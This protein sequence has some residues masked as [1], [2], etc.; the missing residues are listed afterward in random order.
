MLLTQIIT[1][2]RYTDSGELIYI[3]NN[4]IKAVT[5][6]IRLLP[7]NFNIFACEGCNDISYLQSVYY[8]NFDPFTHDHFG[9]INMWSLLAFA[10]KRKNVKKYPLIGFNRLTSLS[11]DT[12][13]LDYENIHFDDSSFTLFPKISYDDMMKKDKF[14]HQQELKI[15]ELVQRL[16]KNRNGEVFII[17]SLA[18]MN[19]SNMKDNKIS[20]SDSNKFVNIDKVI[21]LN[22]NPYIGMPLKKTRVSSYYGEMH[23]NKSKFM[24]PKI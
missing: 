7:P 23:N 20:L 5:D 12:G 3:S 21:L 15:K 14:Y 18:N 22:R 16:E 10:Q 2:I 11:L 4:T 17:D 24:R 1:N 6:I 8:A 19:P 13:K 9:G